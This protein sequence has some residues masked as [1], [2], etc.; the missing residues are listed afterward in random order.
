MNIIIRNEKESD[1]EAIFQI[2]R[3]AFQ[4]HP[5]SHQTGQMI[6]IDTIGDLSG[7]GELGELI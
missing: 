6:C 4:N 2:T 3:A 5:Y 7:E 1:T